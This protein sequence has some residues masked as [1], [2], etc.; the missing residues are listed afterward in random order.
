MGSEPPTEGCTDPAAC[1]Y[2]SSA[3]MDDG[4]CEYLESGEDCIA[5][6]ID[7]EAC[8]YND[9]ANFNDGSCEYPN[10]CTG[11]ENQ[12][13]LSNEIEWGQDYSYFQEENNYS[14]DLTD[15]AGSNITIEFLTYIN[16]ENTFDEDNWSDGYTSIDVENLILNNTEINLYDITTEFN[17]SVPNFEYVE[18]NIYSS[19]DINVYGYDASYD[20]Y[21]SVNGYLDNDWFSLNT[22]NYSYGSINSNNILELTC[23]L[24]CH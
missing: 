20:N 6:C 14:I 18:T 19:N 5:G 22:Y 21:F 7:S 1:N 11:C 15:Y 16:P 10:E 2:D 23:H 4:S 8:N 24:K 9:N 13:L 3:G 17:Y 12:E